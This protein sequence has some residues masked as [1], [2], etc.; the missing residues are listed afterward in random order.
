MVLEHWMPN[1]F[2]VVL[3]IDHKSSAIVENEVTDKGTEAEI[4]TQED[5]VRSE[6]HVGEDGV[7]I[8]TIVIDDRGNVEEVV[9]RDAT[10]EVLIKNMN[11][12]EDNQFALHRVCSS[13]NPITD[14]L[15][16]IVKRQGLISFKKKNFFL[17][18]KDFYQ[19]LRIV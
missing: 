19:N 7:W 15:F 9:L 13:C 1:H 2:V 6:T 11:V 4:E 5:P 3:P 10:K 16:Q 8:D 14:D 12:N 17:K 18:L